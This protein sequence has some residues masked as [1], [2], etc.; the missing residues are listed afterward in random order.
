MAEIIV[1][2]FALR[3]VISVFPREEHIVHAEGIPH[4]SCQ[5]TPCERVVNNTESRDLA[6]WR[7]TL[8]P[9]NDVV[10]TKI[11]LDR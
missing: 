7:L 4:S 2:S 1:A 9:P 3:R 5:T 8:V 11:F 10:Q 6:C